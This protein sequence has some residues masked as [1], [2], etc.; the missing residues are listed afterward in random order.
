MSQVEVDIRHL[1]STKGVRFSW[2]EAGLFLKGFVVKHQDEIYVYE[3]RCPHLGTQLDW[4]QGEFMDEDQRYIICS[5]HGALFEPDSG[6]CVMGPCKGQCLRA[7]DFQIED[8]KL[9]LT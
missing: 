4:T 8:T 5:T 1:T 2:K 9:T 7:L 6:Q 3:N